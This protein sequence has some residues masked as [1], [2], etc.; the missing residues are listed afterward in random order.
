RQYR[1]R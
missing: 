1:G